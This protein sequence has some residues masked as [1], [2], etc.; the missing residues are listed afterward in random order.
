MEMKENPELAA[1]FSTIACDKALFGNR[2]VHLYANES[3]DRLGDLSCDGRRLC[4]EEG[5]SLDCIKI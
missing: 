3:C 4:Q 5:S 2:P 1:I